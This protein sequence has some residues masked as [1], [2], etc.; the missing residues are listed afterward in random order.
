[1]IA[2]KVYSDSYLLL[3]TQNNINSGMI[4]GQI[5]LEINQPGSF[6]FTLIRS[7]PHIENIKLLKSTIAVKIMYILNGNIID[8]YWIFVGR[9]SSIDEDIYGNCTYTCES[10]MAFLKDC[11]MR[12]S[13]YTLEQ[14]GVIGEFFDDIMTIHTSMI[15]DTRTGI[16]YD[17]NR[18]I[19]A[20]P[21]GTDYGYS[22][23]FYITQTPEDE[24]VEWHTMF[25]AVQDIIINAYG[26]IVNFVYDPGADSA[27]E[28]G[29]KFNIHAKY[30]NNH[31]DYFV[32]VTN[33]NSQP[34]VQG[35]YSID[36][37]PSFSFGDNIIE[38]SKTPVKTGIWTCLLPIG[39]DGI[40][41]KTDEGSGWWPERI[42]PVNYMVDRYGIIV[43]QVDF[44]SIEDSATLRSAGEDYIRRFAYTDWYIEN[45]YSIKAVE[46]CLVTDTLYLVKLGYPVR[47]QI[48]DTQEK[49]LNTISI[50][51]D[52]FD[53]QN[54]EYV[55]GPIVPKNIIDEDISSFI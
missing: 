55:I 49:M 29:G 8:S 2:Y 28:S 19:T 45:N 15:C 26:G 54:S 53:A 40:D 24:R 27:I 7:H 30:F 18:V 39:K 20:R 10:A 4:S 21:A 33:S 25:D 38:M 13:N 42:M 48:N 9:P 34:E 17:Y 51:H 14:A 3:D 52:L 43:K 46:P 31:N 6:E 47:V 44:S 23:P 12:Y 36:N 1:M 50:K 16:P 22:D 5:S 32:Y 41:I 37:I 11:Y 35:V